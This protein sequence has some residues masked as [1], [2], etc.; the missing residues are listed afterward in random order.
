MYI[1][2]WDGHLD[3]KIN[4][5]GLTVPTPASILPE[6][7]IAQ[8]TEFRQLPGGSWTFCSEHMWASERAPTMM[9]IYS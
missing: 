8:S 7:S 1:Y 4:R 6:T 2:K 3:I 5:V 9:R